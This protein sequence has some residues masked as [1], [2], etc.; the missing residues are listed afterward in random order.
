MIMV[1]G[2]TNRIYVVRRYT[3]RGEG[4]YVA[5][6]GG[7]DDVTREAIM[8]VEQHIDA[9]CTDYDCPCQFLTRRRQ[10]GVIYPVPV[11]GEVVRACS[12]APRHEC[13]HSDGRDEW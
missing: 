4:L 12:L 13:L 8:S 7:K 3:E 2:L 9:G 5:A 1:G 6:T 10:C 11:P